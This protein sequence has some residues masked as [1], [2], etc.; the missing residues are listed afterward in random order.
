MPNPRLFHDKPQTI[1][2]STGDAE[3]LER[4]AM[5][6][7]CARTVILRE[8]IA[9]GRTGYTLRAQILADARRKGLSLRDYVP[10]LLRAEAQRITSERAAGDPALEQ[11][12]PSHS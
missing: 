7:G 10:D 1:R 12:A 11:R 3:W 4:E 6:R 8:L 2:L 5:R 9:D